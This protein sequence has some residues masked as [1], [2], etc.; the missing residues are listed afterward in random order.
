MTAR[1]QNR[2]QTNALC[3]E[4]TPAQ[5]D[6]L[7]CLARSEHHTAGTFVFREGE[8]ATDLYLID[9]G[10]VGLELCSPRGVHTIDT[11][12]RDDAL[13]L[14]WMYPGARWLFDARATEPLDLVVIDGQRLH[15]LC[16]QDT[17]LGMRLMRAM[18][19][20]VIERLQAT[21]ARLLDFYR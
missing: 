10:R 20:E 2:L 12:D 16:E 4:L 9:A 6:K 17:D 19:R 14:S 8:L 18:A 7:A 13:G 21:R 1:P 15:A 11:L 5:I 3:A